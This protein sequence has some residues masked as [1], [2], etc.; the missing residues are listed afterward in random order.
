MK[1]PKGYLLVPHNE[2]IFKGTNGAFIKN[3]EGRSRFI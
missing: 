2:N 1:Y 3:V